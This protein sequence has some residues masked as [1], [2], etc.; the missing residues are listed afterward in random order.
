MTCH[1]CAL[2]TCDVDAARVAYCA[3]AGDPTSPQWPAVEVRWMTA[4][5]DCQRRRVDWRAR[6][7]AAENLL[8]RLESKP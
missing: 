1:V 8:L 2:A 3:L 7:L 5:R 4:L 6:A